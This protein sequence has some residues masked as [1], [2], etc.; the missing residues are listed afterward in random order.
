MQSSE[1][2][3]SVQSAPLTYPQTRDSKYPPPPVFL[4]LSGQVDTLPGQLT[5]LVTVFSLQ[6]EPA[7]EPA[8]EPAQ[9]PAPPVP[10]HSCPLQKHGKQRGKHAFQK[11][12]ARDRVAKKGSP[13]FGSRFDG[14]KMEWCA[15][16]VQCRFKGGRNGSM[17][18]KRRHPPGNPCKYLLECK[19]DTCPLEHFSVMPRCSFMNCREHN[20]GRCPLFHTYPPGAVSVPASSSDGPV[21]PAK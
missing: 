7:S 18:C 5:P 3:C 1:A 16:G 14:R 15:Y 2:Q 8:Q 17:Q 20:F 12:Q 6:P 21:S 4:T 19:D 10:E 11:W 13:V 9:E